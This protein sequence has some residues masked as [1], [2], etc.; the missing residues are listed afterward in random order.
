M[1]QGTCPKCEHVITNVQ[2]DDISI[3]V[4]FKPQWQGSSYYCP[5]CKA[6]LGVCINPLLVRGEIVGQI[7]EELAKTQSALER[8]I[9]HK[10]VAE[11][12]RLLQQR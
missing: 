5:H 12:K 1:N 2:I 9:T 11:I 7:R 3:D 10:V 6:V 4:G 8:D